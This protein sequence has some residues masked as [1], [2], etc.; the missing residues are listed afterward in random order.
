M[1]NTTSLTLA[2][3]DVLRTVL[4]KYR[5][6]SDGSRSWEKS[7]LSATGGHAHADTGSTNLGSDLIKTCQTR[8]YKSL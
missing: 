6:G 5:R 2:D 8:T 1:L 4:P 7:L 3:T